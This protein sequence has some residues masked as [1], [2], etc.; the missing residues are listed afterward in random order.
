MK[1]ALLTLMMICT[2][3]STVSCGSKTAPDNSSTT[4]DIDWDSIFSSIEN[5]ELDESGLFIDLDSAKEDIKDFNT[6]SFT[7]YGND[8]KSVD[9]QVVIT[10]GFIA[11]DEIEK[12]DSALY[13]INVLDNEDYNSYYY[14]VLTDGYD[15]LF[16]EGK[17]FTDEDQ[18]ITINK[19]ID[20]C[21]AAMGIKENTD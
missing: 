11:N 1:K 17:W 5:A 19:W 15:V 10:Y 2:A 6:I 14:A 20:T 18:T 12:N 3:L 16:E 4:L 21:N 8:F 7:N 9:Y 13:E